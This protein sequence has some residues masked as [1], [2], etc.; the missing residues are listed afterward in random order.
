MSRKN[1][2]QLIPKHKIGGDF[3]VSNFTWPFNDKLLVLNYI[4]NVLGV[5]ENPNNKGLIYPDMSWTT[6]MDRDSDNISHINVGP[7][8][9]SHSNMAAKLGGVKLGSRFSNKEIE[10]VL[11]EDLYDKVQQIKENMRTMQNG[12]YVDLWDNLTDGDK[13]IFLDIAHNVRSR[14]KKKNLPQ[15]FPKLVQAY[16]DKNFDEVGK[17][18]YTKNKRRAEM[19]K[20]LINVKSVNKHTVKNR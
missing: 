6:Y 10:N 20:D 16:Q 11:K 12:K 15:G 8:I 14:N 19:R 9:E 13:M 3:N 4:D 17:E 5:M 2:K 7:G 18:L 1:K